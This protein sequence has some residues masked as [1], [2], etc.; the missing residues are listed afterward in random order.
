MPAMG[1]KCN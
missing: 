1:Q